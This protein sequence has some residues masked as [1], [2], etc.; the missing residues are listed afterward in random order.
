MPIPA[1]WVAHRRDDRELLGWVRPA[2]DGFVAVDLLGRERTDV[3]EW[4]EAERTLDDLGIGY[5]ADPY[6]LRHDD[7]RRLRVRI[8]QVST[9][10][11]RVKNEDWG[12]IDIPLVEHILP[13]P[14]PDALRALDPAAPPEPH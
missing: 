2:G 1:D 10:A 11:I 9:D 7:G 6:E 14:A 3:V 13:F 8:T 5:L 12:A 4:W